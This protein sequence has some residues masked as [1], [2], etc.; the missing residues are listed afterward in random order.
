[1]NVYIEALIVG[2]I[3]LI[4]SVPIMGVVNTYMKNFEQWKF[5]IS[6]V[7]IGFLTH[8]LF[9]FSGEKRRV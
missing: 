4:I 9:E 8:I 5:Y 7:L 2:I 6:T 1:M 3:L